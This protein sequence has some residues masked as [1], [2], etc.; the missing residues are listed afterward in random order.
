MGQYLKENEPASAK[1][2]K[3]SRMLREPYETH[4]KSGIAV[5]ID[6]IVK[7][8]KSKQI[9]IKPSWLIKAITKHKWRSVGGAHKYHIIPKDTV[10]LLTG[11]KTKPTGKDFLG[12]M[13]TYFTNTHI[14]GYLTR[15]RFIPDAKPFRSKD[16]KS[17][18]V[19][20]IDIA[21]WAEHNHIDFTI[22]AI[23][24]ELARHGC[25]PANRQFSGYRHFPI[26]LYQKLFEEEVGS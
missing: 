15:D 13:K 25:R 9:D 21:R 2:A 17:L 1:T 20:A 22:K 23:N 7:W 8:V 6:H 10:L 4:R 18:L 26:T 3:L 14:G 12:F 5:N 16:S 11:M 24:K 19:C